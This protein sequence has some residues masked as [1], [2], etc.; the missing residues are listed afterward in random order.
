MY[1]ITNTVEL[2]CSIVWSTLEDPVY[3]RESGSTT[4]PPQSFI[5]QA[6]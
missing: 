4:E 2:E 5:C 3:S 6:F 1:I